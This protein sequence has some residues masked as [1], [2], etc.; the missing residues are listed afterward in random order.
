[1]RTTLDLDEELLRETQ[2]ELG[3]KG[4]KETI[5]A[6]MREL[7]NARRR[8]RLIAMFGKGYIEMS[9]EELKEMRRWRTFDETD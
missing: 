1:V 2:K 3:T 7:V 6:A 5:E 4:K 8:Q 9:D